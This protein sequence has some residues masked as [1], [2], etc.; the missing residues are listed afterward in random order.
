MSLQTMQRAIYCTIRRNHIRGNCVRGKCEKGR[1][2]G[3][4]EIVWKKVSEVK[5]SKRHG[6][7]MEGECGNK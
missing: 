6:M 5:E 4:D 1:T 7:K 3:K 2:C